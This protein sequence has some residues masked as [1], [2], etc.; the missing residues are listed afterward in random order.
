VLP[1]Q[2]GGGAFG[3]GGGLGGKIQMP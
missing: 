2:G 3:P 1:G